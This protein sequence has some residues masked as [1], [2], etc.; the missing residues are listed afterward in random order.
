MS[1]LAIDF[2]SGWEAREPTSLRRQYKYLN[3]SKNVLN[4]SYLSPF[5]MK[6]DIEI[7]S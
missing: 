4:F 7:V 6:L 3:V 5:I 2:A 1:F